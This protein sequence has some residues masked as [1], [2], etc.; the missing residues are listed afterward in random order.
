MNNK[1]D[2]FIN[3]KPPYNIG[4]GEELY[5]HGR[6]VNPEN[7]D[8]MVKEAERIIDDYIRENKSC[9]GLRRKNI[10]RRELARKKV[11]DLFINTTLV[12]SILVLVFLISRLF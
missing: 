9:A 8:F 7:R 1:K 5:M 6:N 3:Y 11:R 2:L 4:K 12:L 10:L